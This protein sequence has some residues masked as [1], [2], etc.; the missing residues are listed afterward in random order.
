[1]FFFFLSFYKCTVW[2]QNGN[3]SKIMAKIIQPKS[4]AMPINAMIENSLLRYLI[5][6]FYDQ[7][8]QSATAISPC[9]PRPVTHWSR[10]EL[11]RT[12]MGDLLWKLGCCW[13]EVL[14][15]PAG[16]AHPVVC[17]CPNTP[18]IVTGTLYRKKSP[19]F[20]WDV[21]PRS[22]LSVVIKKPMAL[23]IKS[24]V[25]TPVSCGCRR[26]IKADAAHWWWLRRDPPPPHM[27][28]SAL[29]VQQYT[30]KLYIN[31]SII[32]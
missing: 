5:L 9:S 26:I 24:R 30:I 8:Q 29:G 20:G 22:W 2:Q 31:A 7:S 23:L 28:V 17:V 6:I 21:K 1:M 27:I 13:K 10:V 16:D 15:R 3:I 11:V 19:S 18:V 32:N 14:V 4:M 25:V 12:W